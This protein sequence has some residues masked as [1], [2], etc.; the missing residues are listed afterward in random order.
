MKKLLLIAVILNFA[1]CSDDSIENSS[2]NIEKADSE[3]FNPNPTP[4]D[5]LE[6]N[7]LRFLEDLEKSSV[8]KNALNR[9]TAEWVNTYVPDA[10]FRTRLISLGAAQDPTPG[11]SYINIDKTRGGLDLIGAGIT[12]LTGING[13]NSLY[14][15]FVNGNELTTLNISGLTRLGQ[16]NCSSNLLTSLD[17]SDNTNLSQIWCHKNQLTNLILPSSPGLWGVWCY[18]NKLTTLDLNGNIGIKSLFIQGNQLTSFNFAPF[19]NL[20]LTNVSSNNWETL[21]FDSNDALEHFWCYSNDELTSL[22]I[23]NG[24]NTNITGPDF[25]FNIKSPP[26]RVDN[27]RYSN[28][29]WPNKGT[30]VYVN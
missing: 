1:A 22:S 18:D 25:R 4:Q 12:D 6:A 7:H 15:L 3:T 26:I 24:K 23:K 11:D 13:F 29:N 10:A 2:N 19:V 9:N 17:L 21:N 30:S 28:E 27:V 20:E 16:L 14:Q 5:Y 8:H